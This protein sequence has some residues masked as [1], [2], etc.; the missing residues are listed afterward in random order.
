MEPVETRELRRWTGPAEMK[1]LGGWMGLTEQEGP[2]M[3][4]GHQDSRTVLAEEEEACRVGTRNR[5]CG[6][7]GST[8]DIVEGSG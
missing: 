8:I 7:Q 6:I 3:G 5:L 4:P 1:E 2:R